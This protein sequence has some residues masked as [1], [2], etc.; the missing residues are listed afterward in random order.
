MQIF[1]LSTNKPLVL[2][3]SDITAIVYVSLIAQCSM[4]NQSAQRLCRPQHFPVYIHLIHSINSIAAPTPAQHGRTMQA[5]RKTTRRVPRK[6]MPSLARRPCYIE[7]VWKRKQSMRMRK[8]IRAG[9]VRKRIISGTE[10]K[11][12][13]VLRRD[14]QEEA[15]DGEG[16]EGKREKRGM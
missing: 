2:L 11:V 8:W 9:S 1:I 12:D 10:G 15:M 7:S 3:G 14:A 6:E 13:E 16:E 5:R 4:S